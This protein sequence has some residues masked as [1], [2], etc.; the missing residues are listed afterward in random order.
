M[1]ILTPS[2]A[3]VFV[4]TSSTT[5]QS[6]ATGVN[7][8]GISTSEGVVKDAAKSRQKYL[9]GGI[10]GGAVV[11]FIITSMILG[12]VIRKR[13]RNTV[14]EHSIGTSP[15]TLSSEGLS[16]L[17]L[18]RT[19]R[20]NLFA[21]KRRA[22][23]Q[24]LDKPKGIKTSSVETPVETDRDAGHFKMKENL[25]YSALCTSTQSCATDATMI[26]HEYDTPIAAEQPCEYETPIDSSIKLDSSVELQNVYD[27]VTDKEEQIYEEIRLKS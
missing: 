12:T 18:S 10:V 16:H 3:L 21:F 22:T 2:S 15:L 17:Q 24:H 19:T 13:K 11:T 14:V 6:V 1:T 9:I 7:L 27:T 25:C 23:A 5:L 26:G 8:T 20:R 4:G